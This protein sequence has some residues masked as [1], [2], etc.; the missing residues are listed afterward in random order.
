MYNMV[1]GAFSGMRGSTLSVMQVSLSFISL[2][3][4]LSLS[5]MPYPPNSLKTLA[6]TLNCNLNDSVTLR[7]L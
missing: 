4:S 6:Q 7:L 2:S 5:G 1:D 3:E